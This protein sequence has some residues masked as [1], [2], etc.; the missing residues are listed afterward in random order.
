MV[1]LFNDSASI[2]V[3]QMEKINQQMRMDE[4]RQCGRVCLFHSI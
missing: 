4:M 3:L 2:N 1:N